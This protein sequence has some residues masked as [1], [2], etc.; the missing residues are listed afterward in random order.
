M[1]SGYHAHTVNP[2]FISLVINQCDYLGE[3][4]QIDGFL[5]YWFE[6]RTDKCCLLVFIDDVTVGRMYLHFCENEL[7]FDCMSAIR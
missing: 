1:V 3:L 7:A 6:D 4:V 5:H 2:G